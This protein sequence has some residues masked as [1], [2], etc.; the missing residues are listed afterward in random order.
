MRNFEISL[1]KMGRSGSEETFWSLEPDD[2]SY[3][4][5]RE[6]F[7]GGFG[8]V[9]K[10]LKRYYPHMTLGDSIDVIDKHNRRFYVSTSCTLYDESSDLN[11]NSVGMVYFQIA[12]FKY[13]NND[14]EKMFYYDGD[15]HC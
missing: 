7:F 4:W 2:I 3:V 1:V 9:V 11:C 14:G 6:K 12:E 5:T 15:W 13:E 8:A 10:Y